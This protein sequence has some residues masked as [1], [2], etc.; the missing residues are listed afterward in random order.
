MGTREAVH[1]LFYTVCSLKYGE[2]NKLERLVI[3]R[4]ADYEADYQAKL[5]MIGMLVRFV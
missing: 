4:P 5:D 3:G 1:S 2:T